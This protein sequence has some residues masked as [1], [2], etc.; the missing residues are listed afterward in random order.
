MIEIKNKVDCCGCHA[1]MNI[2]PKK[3]IIMKEDDKGFKYP[4]IDK[5]KCI[6][7]GLCNKVC[8][9]LND[10]P[11]EKQIE[12]WAMY[13]KNITERLESSSGGIF[14]LLAKEILK[15]DGVVFGAMFD[16]KF[17]VYHSY[18]LG[19]DELYKLQGSKYVQSNIEDSYKKA[20]EFLDA[21]KYVLFTGTSCQIEGLNHYLNKEYSRLYTQDIICHGVPSPKVWKKYLEYLKQQKEEEISSISFRNKDNGWKA[22]QMKVL[23]GKNTYCMNH[24]DDLFMKSFLWNVCLRDSCY[25][26]KFKKKYRNSDITLGD[27]W[28]INFALPELNDD[29]GISMVILNSVKG[30]EMFDNIKA[31]CVY[32]KTKEEYIFKYNSAYLKSVEKSINREEFFGDLDNI[33]FDKLVNKYIPKITFTKKIK[34]KIRSFFN[35][36]K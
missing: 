19:E 18:I 17:N 3:A 16:E 35:K 1:C 23:F 25:N 24:S 20:K 4:V 5:K 28:G 12:V 31:N 2:C 8:P 22:F 32:E 34:R 30:K 36:E 15:K 9:I 21:G 14:I 6:N 26:C 10:N 27:F 13:N 11:C 7:C 33:E 29:K